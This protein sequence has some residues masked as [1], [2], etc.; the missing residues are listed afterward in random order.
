[1][2]LLPDIHSPIYDTV[3]LSASASCDQTGCQNLH[4][5]VCSISL[6]NLTQGGQE[7][8]ALRLTEICVGRNVTVQPV[9]FAEEFVHGGADP[10]GFD[11]PHIDV[12]ES[13]RGQFRAKRFRRRKL[14]RPTGQRRNRHFWERGQ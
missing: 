9:T 12:L 6:C 14:G 3:R 5:A 13:D 11:L 10:D 1:M 7:M 8:V 4:D 2:S